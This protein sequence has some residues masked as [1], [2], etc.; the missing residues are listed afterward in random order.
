[1]SVSVTGPG[2][3]P[4]IREDI[5]DPYFTTKEVGKGTGMGLAIVLGIVKN[6]SWAIAIGARA[7]IEKPFDNKQLAVLVRSVLDGR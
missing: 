2:I 3:D 7:Y 4:D 5:F 6:H 1:M